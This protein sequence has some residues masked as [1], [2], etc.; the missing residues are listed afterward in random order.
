MRRSRNGVRRRRRAKLSQPN[1]IRL[2]TW[3]HKIDQ[4][5]SRIIP[6]IVTHPQFITEEARRRHGS[7][8]SAARIGVLVTTKSIRSRICFRLTGLI[9]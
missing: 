2:E 5:C 4:G 1:I 3:D 9:R 6:E 7:I 8:N